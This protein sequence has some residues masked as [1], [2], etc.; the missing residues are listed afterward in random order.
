[1]QITDSDPKKPLSTAE[2]L[3]LIKQLK[4]EY[5]H[6]RAFAAGTLG[7]KRAVRAVGPLSSVL[8]Y[9]SRHLH[10]S[11][12]VRSAAAKALGRIGDLEGVAA[13][14]AALS[15]EN[16]VV[17]IAAG[18]AL[19]Q[20][21]TSDILP[22]RILSAPTLTLSQKLDTLQALAGA[23]HRT[24]G[25]FVRYVGGNVQTFCE[26]LCQ[27]PELAEA[28]KREAAAAL[29][30]L[31]NRTDAKVLLRAGM[32]EEVGEKDELLRAASSGS[33]TTVPG[34]LLRPAETSVG[35]IHPE[36]PSLLPRIFKRK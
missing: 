31:R 33:N 16:V 2:T 13:L 34:E 28:L 20:F 11:H 21:G 1:M 25:H 4:T 14:C 12:R 29:V 23:T 9:E 6:I 30:E 8:L 22:L 17:R 32:R 5:W 10:M 19:E 26:H 15:D 35:E 3:A 24:S 36:K 18:Q 27:K 7:L